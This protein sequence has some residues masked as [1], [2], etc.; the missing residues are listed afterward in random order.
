MREA[1]RFQA[2]PDWFEFK[3]SKTEQYVQVGNAVPPILGRKIAEAIISA[4]EQVVSF[5]VP[6]SNYALS[7][8]LIAAS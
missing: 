8:R 5:N 4:S 7:A 6:N 2:F 1:A 3:G